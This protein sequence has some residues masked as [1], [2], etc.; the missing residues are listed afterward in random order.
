MADEAKPW[1]KSKTIW[2][3]IATVAFGIY[4]AVQP[5]LAAHGVSLPDP[6][7]PTIATV[8]AVLAGLGIYGRK[9]ANVAVK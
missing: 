6:N 4:V 3:D 2:S 1:Y 9:T 5:V 7:G 8:L